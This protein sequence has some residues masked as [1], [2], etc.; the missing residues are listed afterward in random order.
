[1]QKHKRR[2]GEL[3]ISFLM[4]TEGDIGGMDADKPSKRLAAA[5][6]GPQRET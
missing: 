6:A 4:G 2:I 1:M 3:G 5:A